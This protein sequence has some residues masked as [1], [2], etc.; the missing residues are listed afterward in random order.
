MTAICYFISTKDQNITNTDTKTI[1]LDGADKVASG[2]QSKS[3]AFGY[4][5]HEFVTWQIGTVM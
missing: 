3:E 5:D 2:Q 4:G 1:R